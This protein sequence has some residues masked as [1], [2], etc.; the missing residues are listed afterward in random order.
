[1][2]SPAQNQK[3]RPDE[4]ATDEKT[5]RIQEN[6]EKKVPKRKP[7]S[8]QTTEK[9]APNEDKRYSNIPP[10][11]VRTKR[12]KAVKKGYDDML[13]TGVL[14]TDKVKKASS[15]SSKNKND[16]YDTKASRKMPEPEI[17]IMKMIITK[18]FRDSAQCA[19]FS[20]SS[21]SQDSDSLLIK[22]S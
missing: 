11:Q 9:S 3:R 7:S 13:A 16:K 12:E 6:P 22:D 8:K 21:L 1:M 10:E 5:V 20:G 4:K 17:E 14:D 2:K 19:S 15:K 18:A